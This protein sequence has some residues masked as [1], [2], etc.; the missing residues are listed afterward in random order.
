MEL[1]SVVIPTYNRFNFLLQAIESVKKQTYPNI[2][3]IVVND[4]S[5]ESLYYTYDWNSKGITIIHLQENSRKR[6]GFP[7]AGFVRNK[8]IEASHGTYVAFCDDDDSWLP[9]KIQLQMDCMKL[10]NCKMSSTD[11]FIGHGI[12]DPTQTYKRYNSE[13]YYNTLQEIY[14]RKGS[15]LL[16]SGFPDIWT[17][18][19]IQIHNC[20]ITSS[21][22]VHK[23]ILNNVHNFDCLRNGQEDYDCWLR[24]LC[25]TNSVYVTTPCFYY[26]MGHGYGS[27]H[28]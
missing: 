11:G 14:S 28:S 20:I 5:T 15:K 6:F 3:I 7:C 13:Y 16:K 21:V 19:F 9:N 27:N 17:L 25:H 23:E 12:Y 10:Y 1:V 26:D 18:E 22:I 8:G 4:C 24:C 2:E